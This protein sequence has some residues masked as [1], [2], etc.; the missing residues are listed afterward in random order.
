MDALYVYAHSP[1]AD[2]EIRQSLRSL[3]E[4]APYIRKVWIYGDRPHFLCDDPSIVEHVPHAATAGVLGVKTPVVN[5]FLLMFLCNC[6][7]SYRFV[8]SII[9]IW[10][11]KNCIN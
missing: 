4:N 5:F 8:F 2:F 1:H 10:C 6:H 11:Q 9:P 3:A 7:I